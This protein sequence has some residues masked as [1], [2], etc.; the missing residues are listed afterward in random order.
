MRQ[1]VFALALL[2]GASAAFA[3]I[4]PSPAQARDYPYCLNEPSGVGVPG[5]CSYTSYNQCM[6]S[7]SGR[8]AWCAINPRVAFGPQH[9]RYERPMPRYYR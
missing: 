3:V 2:G 5:D 9:N 7:A 4:G 6:M 1:M 8:S